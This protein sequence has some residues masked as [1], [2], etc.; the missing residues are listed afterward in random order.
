MRNSNFAPTRRAKKILLLGCVEF[1]AG[2][3]SNV[4]HYLLEGEGDTFRPSLFGMFCSLFKTFIAAIAVN[5]LCTLHRPPRMNQLPTHR[6]TVPPHYSH[7]R[8]SSR[9]IQRSTHTI[10][11]IIHTWSNRSCIVYSVHL[12]YSDSQMERLRTILTSAANILDNMIGGALECTQ[13]DHCCQTKE[14]P[15]QPKNN[16]ST[17]RNKTKKARHPQ[18]HR[19]AN[20]VSISTAST[21]ASS[22]SSGIMVF[23][24]QEQQQRRRSRS[25]RHRSIPQDNTANKPPVPSTNQLFHRV[26]PHE[27][28]HLP[29]RTD[30]AAI[31]PPSRFARREDTAGR[32]NEPLVDERE[33]APSTRPPHDKHGTSTPR[34]WTSHRNRPSSFLVSASKR[35]SRM[36]GGSRDGDASPSFRGREPQPKSR[37]VPREILVSTTPVRTRNEIPIVIAVPDGQDLASELSCDDM[38]RVRSGAND[39]RDAPSDQGFHYLQPFEDKDWPSDEDTLGG[40]RIGARD[41]FKLSSVRAVKGNLNRVA[42]QKN[43]D[44]GRRSTSPSRGLC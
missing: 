22:T 40:Q 1:I 23:Q 43:C 42:T 30:K 24:Q 11:P 37:H 25:S 33:P 34:R 15:W 14:E 38:L 27:E 6:P 28:R 9:S 2:E 29:S 36:L 18:G 17:K 41:G 31:L 12:R 21:S 3:G 32:G 8:K 13:N 5:A 16:T 20:C 19:P 26:K 10:S 35:A 4:A 7:L 44:M 39:S